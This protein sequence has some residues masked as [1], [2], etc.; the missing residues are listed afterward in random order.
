[1]MRA[2]IAILI[3]FMP[4]AIMLLLMVQILGLVS[5]ADLLTTVS[6]AAFYS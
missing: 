6:A 3:N 4:R 5:N 2:K 1:M